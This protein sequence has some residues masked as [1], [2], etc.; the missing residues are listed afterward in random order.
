MGNR[1]LEMTEAETAA[2]DSG[3]AITS[4]TMRREVRAQAQAEADEHGQAVEVYSDDGITLDAIEP[5]DPGDEPL[6]ECV[7]CGASGLDR[8]DMPGEQDAD[9]W[10]RIVADHMPGCDWAETRAHRVG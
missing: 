3:D 10:A 7:Y 5:Q 9:A 8:E 6:V 4:E 1:A 2:W